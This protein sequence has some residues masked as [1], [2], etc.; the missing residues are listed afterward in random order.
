MALIRTSNAAIKRTEQLLHSA[1]HN[2]IIVRMIC[3]TFV[4]SQVLVK[5]LKACA[6][7]QTERR[8]SLQ[9]WGQLVRDRQSDWLVSTVMVSTT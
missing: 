9:S 6:D 3:L 8:E 1:L 7:V 4:I 5:V 2:L